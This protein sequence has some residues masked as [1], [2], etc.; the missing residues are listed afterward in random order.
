MKN[1]GKLLLVGRGHRARR[2]GLVP[3]AS[4]FSAFSLAFAAGCASSQPRVV[5]VSQQKRVETIPEVD[6]DIFVSDRASHF[7]FPSRPLPV[8]QQREEFFV[9]WRPASVGLVKFEY[10]Q[11]N[12]PNKISVQEYAPAGH[13]STTF[14]VQGQQ[15]VSGGSVSAWRVSLW[16]NSQMVAQQSSVLW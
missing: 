11:V 7:R 2:C 9:R 14:R 1:S 15:F 6:R 3:M 4:F 16:N 12:T 8:D 13:S 5:E 10:R